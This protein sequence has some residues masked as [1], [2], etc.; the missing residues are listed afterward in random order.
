M[1]EPLYN[2]EVGERSGI[3]QAPRSTRFTDTLAEIVADQ[4]WATI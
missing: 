2:W 3:T 4:M 1:L